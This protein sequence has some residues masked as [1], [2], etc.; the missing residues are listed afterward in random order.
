MTQD[1]NKKQ[2]D[3]APAGLREEDK[4]VEENIAAQLHVTDGD[5]IEDN[6]NPILKLIAELTQSDDFR[7]AQRTIISYESGDSHLFRS[8]GK[9]LIIGET[10]VDSSMEFVSTAFNYLKEKLTNEAKNA[11]E[12]KRANRGIKNI[13]V[14]TIPVVDQRFFKRLMT[15]PDYLYK[16]LVDFH[17][18][19]LSSQQRR[20]Y[21]KI[22]SWAHQKQEPNFV[23]WIAGDHEVTIGGEKRIKKGLKG[24]YQFVLETEPPPQIKKPNDDFIAKAMAE[25]KTYVVDKPNWLEE[26]VDD[27]DEPFMLLGKVV[28]DRIT[29][30]NYVST[31]Q[32]HIRAAIQS[33]H[34]SL[35]PFDLNC[36]TDDP[37]TNNA[38]MITAI[39]N[40]KPYSGAPEYIIWQDSETNT[41]IMPLYDEWVTDDNP[42]DKKTDRK[43]HFATII[44]LF[45]AWDEETETILDKLILPDAVDAH[46]DYDES[47]LNVGYVTSDIEK[48]DQFKGNLRDSF[49]LN[50][51]G[52]VL[53][54]MG[55][56][57]T[58]AS[59]RRRKKQNDEDKR[60]KRTR[61]PTIAPY[62]YQYISACR[63][64]VE[65]EEG[66]LQY[67][68]LLSSDIDFALARAVFKKW[69]ECR[70]AAGLDQK[71][72]LIICAKDGQIG[73]WYENVKS[74]DITTYDNHNELVKIGTCE[75]WLYGQWVVTHYQLS[76]VWNTL[77]GPWQLYLPSRIDDTGYHPELAMDRGHLEILLKTEARTLKL[78][79][80]R[81]KNLCSTA[82]IDD[83]L[84]HFP[85][86]DG[87]GTIDRRKC[88]PLVLRCGAFW[89]Y[90][91]NI[92]K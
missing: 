50:E 90:I 79:Y 24:A 92:T 20:K 21:I 87:E 55:A 8:M 66:T 10:I 61:L 17:F 3:Q 89:I 6:G 80:G 65:N 91:H 64:F 59:H 57:W 2:A 9:L 41:F 73:M 26:C 4:Y 16:T 72:N 29:F 56:Q 86:K 7:K 18:P 51:D 48:I 5:V 45:D 14:P 81:M 74:E 37:A 67:A 60:L 22:L 69:S 70:K 54:F 68:D 13:G 39:K 19:N 53:E 62:G 11:K 38:N 32:T 88:V 77:T 12:G 33:G 84:Y 49:R 1:S 42:K 44:S 36:E 40:L 76:R 43:S 15:E 83:G 23:T 52:S 82:E 85:L 31:N 58:H 25:A 34:G 46:Q 35:F 71:P 78:P 63:S 47:V 75:D 28:D 30:V 27:F